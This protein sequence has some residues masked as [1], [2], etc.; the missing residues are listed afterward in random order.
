M[1]YK[2]KIAWW[3]YLVFALCILPILIIWLDPEIHLTKALYGSGVLVLVNLGMYYL[4]INTYYQI[5]DGTLTV[6]AGFLIHQKIDI[7]SIKRIKETN[8][9]LIAPA[10]SLDR[11]SIDYTKGSTLISPKLKKEFIAHLL[12][13]NPDI[14][15]KYK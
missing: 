12:K 14:E 10:M 8:N 1:K 3:L 2:S 6:K 7:Q 9:P 4:V 11:L 15:V 5:E 13:V